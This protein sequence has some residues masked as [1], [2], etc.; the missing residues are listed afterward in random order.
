MQSIIILI[1]E[2]R[3]GGA[4]CYAAGS[5]G[6]CGDSGICYT[7]YDDVIDQCFYPHKYY[8]NLGLA[9]CSMDDPACG[10]EEHCMPLLAMSSALAAEY[11]ILVDPVNLIGVTDTQVSSYD[12]Y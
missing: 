11:R 8:D 12:L 4:T 9:S 2:D 5:C 3:D 1:Y 10:S 7:R 6:N